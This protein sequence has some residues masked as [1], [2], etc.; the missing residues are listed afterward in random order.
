MGIS[1]KLEKFQKILSKNIVKDILQK[2]LENFGK[3]FRNTWNYFTN[4]SG[5]F[6]DFFLGWWGEGDVRKC[7]KF[8]D[9]FNFWNIG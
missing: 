4:I 2:I 6:K 5:K 7:W 9:H 3:I 1:H 8:L